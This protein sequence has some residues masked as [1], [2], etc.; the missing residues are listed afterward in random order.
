MDKKFRVFNLTQMNIVSAERQERKFSFHPLSF[1][2]FQ[3]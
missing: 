3:N 1:P 2:L